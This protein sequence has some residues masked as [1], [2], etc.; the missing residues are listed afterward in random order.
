MGVSLPLWL[1]VGTP[2]AFATAADVALSNFALVRVPA[3]VYTLIKGTSLVWTAFFSYSMGYVPP[4][5]ALAVAVVVVAGGA[6]LTAVG[7]SGGDG[8][9]GGDGGGT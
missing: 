1:W 2:I 6:A 4:S 9:G 3:M 8:S 5:W 7:G